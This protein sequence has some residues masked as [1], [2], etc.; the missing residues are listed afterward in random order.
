MFLVRGDLPHEEVWTE[1]IGSL[2][3]LVPYS[4][5]CDSRVE[6]CYR[7]MLERSSPPKSVYD[8][9]TYFS[10]VVHTKPHFEG[11]ESGSIFDGRIVDDRIEVYSS[12]PSALHPTGKISFPLRDLTEH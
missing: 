12:A 7:D 5:L 2:A 4:V 11:Y 3:G 1:W 6:R 9:Q 8:K 10:I